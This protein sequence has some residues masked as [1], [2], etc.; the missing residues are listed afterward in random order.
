MYAWVSGSASNDA[1]GRRRQP[2][3]GVLAELTFRRDEGLRNARSAMEAGDWDDAA[4]WEERAI[5]SDHAIALLH[6]GWRDD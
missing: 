2:N 1:H 6:D 5:V 4:D 3:Q